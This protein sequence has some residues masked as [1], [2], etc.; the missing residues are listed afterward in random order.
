MNTE[1]TE[2]IYL[3]HAA[4][5]ALHVE[6]LEAMQPFLTTVFGN[7][8]S[9]HGRGR[10]ARVAVEKARKQIAFLLNAEP[11]ELFFTSGGTES[12]NT[13]FVVAVRDL[14]CHHLISSPIEHHAVLHPFEHYSLLSGITSSMAVLTREGGVDYADLKK[15]LYH[16]TRVGRKCFISLMGA[17]NETGHLLDFPAVAELAREFNAV[18]H[19]DG[20]QQ[21]GHYPLD[22]KQ[23]GVHF[24]SAS[25]H[26]FGGPK[27]V[28]LLYVREGIEMEPFVLGGGQESGRRAGTENVAA[29]VG[30]AK[31]LEVAMRDFQR[32]SQHI[33]LLKE[34]LAVQLKDRV[35]GISF[36]GDLKKGLYTVLSV[37]FPKTENTASLL[38][39]L[40]QRGICVSGGAACSLGASS[41][42]MRQLGKLAGAVTIRFS[43]GPRNTVAEIDR[44]VEVVEELL[45]AAV[46]A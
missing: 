28:G 23:L 27:G 25:A 37:N 11:S 6:V 36:N 15:Q 39:A 5:T 46:A 16:F 18:F 8:S 24:L 22:V 34:R 31:A 41:H 21:V 17:N 42:V 33:Q 35:E 12:N 40:D 32:N 26:K 19:S 45:R 43:F 1:N 29:I 3:D 2:T 7:P 10:E 14:H 4:T 38:S 30:L 20:V 13:A 44:V 9:I